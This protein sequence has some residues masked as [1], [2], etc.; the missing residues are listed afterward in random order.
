[1]SKRKL[2][3]LIG[4]PIDTFN[5]LVEEAGDSPVEIAILPCHKCN[6]E[7]VVTKLLKDVVEQDL[8]MEQVEGI[9]LPCFVRE[10]R[11]Q[12]IGCGFA[13][14]SDGSVG[15]NH[16][17]KSLEAAFDSLINQLAEAFDN[18]ATCAEA[19]KALKLGEPSS[20]ESQFVHKL[21]E[22][23]F[24]PV[25]TKKS[26]ETEKESPPATSPTDKDQVDDLFS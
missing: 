5:E 22:T 3:G 15:S 16:L 2:G 18:G 9:C 7:V 17:V 23:L 14:K 21:Q 19:V 1:M 10:A 13:V 26:V 20:I 8:E 25:K 4:L 11:S 6:C 12:N 24:T